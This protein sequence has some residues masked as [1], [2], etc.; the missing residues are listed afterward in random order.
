MLKKLCTNMRNLG[1]DAEYIAIKDYDFAVT[2][3]KR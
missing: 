2:Q 3:A 1:I